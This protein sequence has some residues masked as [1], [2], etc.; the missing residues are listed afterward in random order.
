MAAHLILLSI[1]HNLLQVW[2]GVTVP[3]LAQAVCKLVLE[4]SRLRGK[5]GGNS[6]DSGESLFGGGLEAGEMLEG[7]K[8]AETAA[9]RLG[10]AGE[11]LAEGENGVGGPV[12][13]GN[14]GGCH[15]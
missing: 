2:D 3:G 6:L 11:D 8:S 14:S 5:G 4:E 10:L 12:G 7:E 13:L 1:L 15:V 9:K